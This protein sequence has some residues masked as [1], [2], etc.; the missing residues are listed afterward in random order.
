MINRFFYKSS[1]SDFIYDSVDTVFGRIS[2]NDE[3]DSVA[4]QKYA[5]SEEIEIMQLVLQPWKDENG[6]ELFESV[7]DDDDA[8]PHL[9]VL[10]PQ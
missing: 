4:E 1:L 7:D 10:A 6:E 3:G 8:N 9:P 5:W 2:R